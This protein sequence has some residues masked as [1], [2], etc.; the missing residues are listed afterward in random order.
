MSD[1]LTL[2]GRRRFLVM[3]IHPILLAALILILC[4]PCFLMAETN[5]VYVDAFAN[6]NGIGTPLRP[7]KLI[8]EAV[9]NATN[10]GSGDVLHVHVS[11]GIYRETISKAA[12]L[13]LEANIIIEGDPLIRPVVKGSD[14]FDQ[15]IHVQGAE[16]ST[17]WPHDLFAGYPEYTESDPNINDWLY[18]GDSTNTYRAEYL[19]RWEGVWIDGQRLRQILTSEEKEAGTFFVD[20][21]NDRLYVWLDDDSSPN[22]H[23]VEIAVRETGVN[24]FRMNNIT[25]RNLVFSHAQTGIL[26]SQTT[27]L[28]V[29]NS[30]MSENVGD[31]IRV[32]LMESFK[33]TDT[34]AESNGFNGIQ[35]SYCYS[36]TM[37]TVQLLTNNWRGAQVGAGGW[38]VG[39][40]K[41]YAV[42]DVYMTDVTA[43][44]N[45]SSG[46]WFDRYSDHVVM[47]SC[48]MEGNLGSGLF[49]EIS[50]GPIEISNCKFLYNG[51]GL[52]RYPDLKTTY[53]GIL[54]N[55]GADLIATNCYFDRN[56]PHNVRIADSGRRAPLWKEGESGESDPINVTGLVFTDCDFYHEHPYFRTVHVPE[57]LDPENFWLNSITISPDPNAPPV[58]APPNEEVGEEF[59]FS[60]SPNPSVSRM[61][62]SVNLPSRSDLRVRVYDILGRQV[63]ALDIDSVPR[64]IY[65]TNIDGSQLASGA[66][67]V[68]V[69]AD[70]RQIGIQKVVVV[71]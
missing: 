57:F 14:V 69:A 15:W 52:E 55:S 53:S 46:I 6:D 34:M 35:P 16:Y 41:L 28:S 22:D 67:F 60:T 58:A 21:D 32:G 19:T 64:G 18:E 26:V 50:P 65:R 36:L 38:Q 51:L 20:Q 30:T 11:P 48:L 47:K 44:N 39:G 23:L 27:S 17:V 29:E 42:A 33:V 25:L 8:S 70:G 2:L 54:I 3:R 40:T 63:R 37:E 56:Y 59:S 49:W 68:E 66:Y 24:F 12:W 31:G 10:Y 62:L 7:Y 45:R 4:L 1:Y 5:H 9:S 13:S 61:L 71:K 43:K